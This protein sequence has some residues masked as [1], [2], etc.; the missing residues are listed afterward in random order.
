MIVGKAVKTRAEQFEQDNH[1]V[2][3]VFGSKQ[4]LATYFP[5]ILSQSILVKTRSALAVRQ[6]Q[7]RA[8]DQLAEM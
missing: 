2:D 4:R 7:M 8:K 5:L 1:L 3:T 6:V